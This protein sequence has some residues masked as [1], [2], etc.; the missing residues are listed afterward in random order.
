MSSTHDFPTYRAD[1][2]AA[3]R[4][5]HVAG[6][7]LAGIG[8]GWMLWRSLPQAVWSARLALLVYASGVLCMLG[9]S[10]AYNLCP[11][12]LLKA[13]LRV[14]DHAAIFVMIAGSYTPYAA[15]ALPPRLGVPLVV[16]I[17]SIAV[18]GVALTVLR[19]AWFG[20][21][22]LL[23]YLAMGWLVLLFIHALVMALPTLVLCLLLGGGLVYSVGTLLHANARLRFHNALWH[24]MVLSAALLHLAAITLLFAPA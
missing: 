19:P 15:R 5:V 23:L 12:G 17:W 1:E 3:D 18:V 14:L 20:R 6:L 21:M 2:V 7:L 10:A 13:R 16:A 8:L 11:A 24:L 9:A 22:A 4:L